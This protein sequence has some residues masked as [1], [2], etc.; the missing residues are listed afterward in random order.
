MSFF[1]EEASQRLFKNSHI[2]P[3]HIPAHSRSSEACVSV[4]FIIAEYSVMTFCTS[5]FPCSFSVH[6]R[7]ISPTV[8]INS[9]K[10]SSSPKNSYIQS[11]TGRRYFSRLP[12]TFARREASA[13]YFRKCSFIVRPPRCRQAVPEQLSPCLPEAPAAS[14][15]ARMIHRCQAW[16]D[17][18]SAPAR[19]AFCVSP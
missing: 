12:S 3:W 18:A 15:P 6:T 2:S 11:L 8:V 17:P 4:M 1:D 10:G 5:A 13:S 14:A 19:R 16:S 9:P 7:L